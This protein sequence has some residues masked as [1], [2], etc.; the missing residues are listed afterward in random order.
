MRIVRVHHSAWNL[1]K[2]HHY[3]SAGIN[4]AAACFVGLIK[5]R[6]A[7]FT[8]VIHYPHPGGSFWKAH[9]TVVLPDFQGLGLGVKI[10]DYVAGLF[11]STGKPVR[12]NASHPALCAARTRSKNWRCTRGS[13][14]ANR[15][16]AKHSIRRATAQA[17]LTMSFE[18]VGEKLAVDAEKFG[19]N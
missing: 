15:T 1:F 3:L 17:R 12:T 4:R 18:Y 9:R 7:A 16:N 2:R 6:P 8:S 14:F 13:H 10:S 11:A 19:V 5:E